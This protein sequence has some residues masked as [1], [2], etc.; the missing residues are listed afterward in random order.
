MWR[1]HIDGKLNE[2]QSLMFQYPRPTDEFYDTQSDPYEV[3]NLADN[4]EYKAE[5]NNMSNSLDDWIL[6]H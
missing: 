5:L 6:K 3:N 2:A 4:P 1:L